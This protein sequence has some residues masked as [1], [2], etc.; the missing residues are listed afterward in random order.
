M[1]LFNNIE[2]LEKKEVRKSDSERL[3]EL[4][5]T[6]LKISSKIHLVEPDQTLF[7]QKEL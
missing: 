1:K 4:T 2:I 7:V 5:K 3:R 6:V